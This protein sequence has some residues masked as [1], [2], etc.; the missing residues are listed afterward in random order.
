MASAS[1]RTHINISLEVSNMHGNAYRIDL[2]SK[3]EKKT[4]INAKLSR[5]ASQHGSK[6]GFSSSSS[7]SFFSWPNAATLEAMTIIFT[8]NSS[9]LSRAV[10]WLFL[11]SSYSSVTR[12]LSRVTVSPTTIQTLNHN[13]QQHLLIHKYLTLLYSF[14]MSWDFLYTLVFRMFADVGMV[15][16]E[17]WWM[18]GCL[19]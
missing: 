4:N 9:I 3:I 13:K 10:H 11:F 16:R 7:S 19:F 18:G 14:L 2:W 17:V 5:A 1:T 12:V 8:R 15:V 6:F